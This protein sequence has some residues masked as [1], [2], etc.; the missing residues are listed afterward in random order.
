MRRRVVRLIVRTGQGRGDE[1]CVVESTTGSMTDRAVEGE[2]DCESDREQSVDH[3]HGGISVLAAGILGAAFVLMVAVLALAAVQAAR[4]IAQG[5]ADLGS[6]AAAQALQL[7]ADGPTACGRAERV[8]ADNEGHLA[9][10]RI[11]GEEVVLDVTVP[12][13]L[14]ALGAHEAVASARAGPV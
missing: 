13:H 6:L 7:G 14:G 12:V 3:E 8:V 1:E 10:C 11:E 4:H 5:A 9:D 2:T